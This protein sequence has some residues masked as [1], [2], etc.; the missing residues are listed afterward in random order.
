MLETHKDTLPEAYRSLLPLLLTPPVWTQRG[1]I[2]A[3]VRLINA[4]L[5][6]DAARMEAEGQLKTVIAIIQQ[7]LVPSKLNDQYGFE[8]IQTMVEVLPPAIL[9]NV[10]FGAILTALFTRLQTSKTDKFAYSLAYLMFFTMAL[11]VEGMGPE[12]VVSEVEKVQAGLWAQ[13]FNGIILPEVHKTRRHDTKVVAVGLARLL[14][15]SQLMVQP[16]HAQMWQNAFAALEKLLST[17]GAL[18]TSAEEDDDPHAALTAIDYEEQTAGYQAAF[19]KLAA[20][21][22]QRP[23]P[24]AYIPDAEVF[25]KLA[26]S[27]AVAQNSHIRS[28]LA[29]MPQTPWVQG[30]R[31]S[32]L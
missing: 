2:P 6:K 21:Q 23:H 32:H 7:R 27:Q 26:L 24:I 4:F 5:A 31:S 25:V 30:L 18:A 29:S 22:L 17:K 20:S 8:L 13:L 1:S 9:K 16:Q 14:T 12:F 19:S 10:Y 28:L 11:N 15:E 3:L